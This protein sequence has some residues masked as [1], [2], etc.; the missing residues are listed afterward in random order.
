MVTERIPDGTKYS[1]NEPKYVF[2]LCDVVG[3]QAHSALVITRALVQFVLDFPPHM[4]T[5]QPGKIMAGYIAKKRHAMLGH[6]FISLSR[7]ICR[8]LPP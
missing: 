2:H 6:G 3:S 5:T 1:K 7:I 4:P 8:T